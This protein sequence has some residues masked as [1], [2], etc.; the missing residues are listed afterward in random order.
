KEE[1]AKE[2]IKEETQSKLI[3]KNI[4]FFAYDES[5]GINLS[6]DTKDN[7]YRV[8]DDKGT[9]ASKVVKADRITS[10]ELKIL[11]TR[12]RLE[13]DGQSLQFLENERVIKQWEA[14]SGEALVNLK[15]TLQENLQERHKE[16]QKENK[17]EKIFDILVS[18]NKARL[19]LKGIEFTQKDELCSLFKAFDIKEENRISLRIKETK[20]I[21]ILIERFKESTKATM[22]RM[23]IYI[24]GKR[25]DKNGKFIEN[26]QSLLN[27]AYHTNKLISLNETKLARLTQR[28]L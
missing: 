22:A 2:E 23:N 27:Q 3:N 15:E 7:A 21:L 16:K 18:Y 11:Q 10:I 4:I 12:F 26:S 9:G 24:D 20:R 6:T 13:F 8:Y 17:Q 1:R 19:D 14:R 25:V 5:L 28:A